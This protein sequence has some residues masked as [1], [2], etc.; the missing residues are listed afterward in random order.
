LRRVEYPESECND[1]NRINTKITQNRNPAASD[2]RP[3]YGIDTE[4]TPE[5]DMF[6]LADSDGRFIDRDMM[7]ESVADFLLHR[8]YQ[9]AYN[10]CF[11]LHYDAMM[12][13]KLLGDRLKSYLQSRILQWRIDDDTR[14]KYIPKKCLIIS[15]GNHSV[16]IYDVAQFYDGSLLDVYEKFIGPVPEWYRKK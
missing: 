10:V 8:K 6:L 14:I 15:R 2:P 9:G 13:L 3:F 5:G 16:C 12:I 11:N 7:I 4:A 1:L